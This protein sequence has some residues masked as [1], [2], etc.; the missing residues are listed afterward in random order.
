MSLEARFCTHC[1]ATAE[2]KSVYD[3]MGARMVWYVE[4]TECGIK[5]PQLKVKSEVV[6]IWNLR[7]ERT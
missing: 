6:K 2:V 1:G 4:C 7:Y 5:T 3:F